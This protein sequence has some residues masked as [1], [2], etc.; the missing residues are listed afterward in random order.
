MN[1]SAS[2]ALFKLSL[3]ASLL[4]FASHYH[5][6]Q[7]LKHLLAKTQ[8]VSPKLTEDDQDVQIKIDEGFKFYSEKGE[9]GV[10]E[11]KDGV[12]IHYVKFCA[13]HDKAIVF[14]LPGWSETVL[15]YGDFF[16]D[17]VDSGIS[18]VAMDHRSQGLS[19]RPKRSNLT[20][21]DPSDTLKSH[22]EDFH[23]HIT[24]ALLIYS[25]IVVPLMKET[26]RRVF[27]TGFSLG[28]LVALHMSTLVKCSGLILLA[29]CVNT[30]LSLPV[31]YLINLLRTMG[32]GESFPP[33]FPMVKNHQLLYPPNSKVSSSTIRV[34]FWEK[35]R[36]EYFSQVC[37][38][39][40]SIAHIDELN[41]WNFT[42]DA[43]LKRIL[44]PKILM[45]SA[46]IELFVSNDAIFDF[47]D[48]MKKNEQVFCRHIHIKGSKHEILH[49]NQGIRSIAVEEIIKFILW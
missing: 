45:I 17:L 6:K 23:E 26:H 30:N 29:P 13:E 20:S 25:E 36:K 33:G 11:G 19:G 14:M 38:N 39:S 40:L 44:A 32:F 27:F 22:V 48:R 49:E 7:K 42:S 3:I 18:V 1:S 43:C 24:D 21:L 9:K 5:R 16:K 37:L 41:K 10:L 47:I 46:E 4:F 15:K 34:K 2:S 35:L 28:G 8:V 31:R 12:E